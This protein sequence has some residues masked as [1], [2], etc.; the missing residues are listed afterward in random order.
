MYLS[1]S[2]K[3]VKA[4]VFN[5]NNERDIY[6]QILFGKY[7]G[8]EVHNLPKHYIHWLL[9]ECT[10]I[11]K[12]YGLRDECERILGVQRN[13]TPQSSTSPNPDKNKVNMAIKSSF[14]EMSKELHP[15]RQGTKEAF[16]VLNN[17]HD[18]LRRILS[19]DGCI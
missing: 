8:C 14:R 12:F 16:Q 3:E 1:E 6:M 4:R 7:K 17:A 13:S 18:R 11:D 19:Q 2:K 10:Y 5:L 15:D 9:K